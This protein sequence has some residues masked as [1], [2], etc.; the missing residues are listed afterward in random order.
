MDFLFLFH[1]GNFL[2]YAPVNGKKYKEHAEQMAK[3]V[4]GRKEKAKNAGKAKEQKN[5]TV[6]A[7]KV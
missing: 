4:L 7:E 5:G 3:S 1:K 2:L 6:P